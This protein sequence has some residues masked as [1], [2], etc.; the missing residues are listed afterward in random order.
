MKYIELKANE[1]DRELFSHFIRRQSVTQC[2]RK[3]DG[4]WCIKDAPFTDD[5]TEDEYNE[6]IACLKN[7]ITT[8]GFVLG[9]FSDGTLKGFVSVE[10]A[11]F[12]KNKEYLDLSSIHIS[13][14]MRGRGIGKELFQLAKVWAKEHGAKK[15]YISAH[16][17]VESQ[18]FYRAMGCVEAFEYNQCHVEKEPYDCQL[19]CLL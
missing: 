8:G 13:E 14:D 10:P 3:I 17:A 12:G 15:L 6:L 18:A 7:T 2:W 9:A 19:E 11:L 5:W 4:K 16:S 1:I